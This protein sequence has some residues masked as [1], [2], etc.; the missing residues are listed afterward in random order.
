MAKVAFNPD[1]KQTNNIESALS[2][3][4]SLIFRS[5]VDKF[6]TL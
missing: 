4:N 1:T 2:Q 5:S 3:D 6:F